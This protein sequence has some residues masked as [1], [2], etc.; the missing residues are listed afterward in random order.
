MGCVEGTQIK[1]TVW[2][3]KSLLWQRIVYII[4]IPPGL[5]VLWLH[6]DV[7]VKFPSIVL[8]NYSYVLHKNKS[9]K[10]IPTKYQCLF[11]NK[12]APSINPGMNGNDNFS[13]KA[14]LIHIKW[15]ACVKCKHFQSQHLYTLY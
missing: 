15:S 11:F 3:A 9:V 12:I 10:Q 1:G 14:G 6:A 13:C 7:L 8:I 4:F 2:Q 5:N